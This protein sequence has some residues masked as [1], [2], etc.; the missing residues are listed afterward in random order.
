MLRPE[1]PSSTPMRL[2][3]PDIAMPFIAEPLDAP[4]WRPPSQAAR[5][6]DDRC[7]QRDTMTAMTVPTAAIGRAAMSR[8]A[9]VGSAARAGTS[10][11]TESPISATMGP[12]LGSVPRT[13]QELSETLSGDPVGESQPD[14]EPDV[15]LGAVRDQRSEGNDERHDRQDHGHPDAGADEGVAERSE[16]VGIP[17]GLAVRRGRPFGSR[18]IS[19]P[20]EREHPDECFE[21]PD[22]CPYEQR[23]GSAE[24]AAGRSRRLGADGV[25]IGGSPQTSATPSAR[26]G[27]R[28]RR[29]PARPGGG[30]CAR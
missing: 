15:H 3:E 27:C 1:G 14:A 10:G 9:G 19:R 17:A 6:W 28:S 4:S 30:T 12:L 5:R 26:E 29:L 11:R 2:V 16:Q 25:A 18:W 23:T 13:G 21:Q 8:V 20:V 22:G 7:G 24:E